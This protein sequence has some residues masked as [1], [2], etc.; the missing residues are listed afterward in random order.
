MEEAENL[1]APDIQVRLRSS[2]DGEEFGPIEG[3]GQDRAENA[4]GVALL[5]G[6]PD[7]T[8]LYVFTKL[9]EFM[10]ASIFTTTYVERGRNEYFAGF[11]NVNLVTS[12]HEDR[13]KNKWIH[14]SLVFRASTFPMFRRSLE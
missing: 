11:S 6:W 9:F 3:E 14:L 8:V 4:H 1:S 12:Y 5:D 7:T 2:D 13:N 10:W